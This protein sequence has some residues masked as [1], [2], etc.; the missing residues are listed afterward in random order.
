VGLI[1]WEVLL[2]LALSFS[3]PCR[4]AISASHGLSTCSLVQTTMWDP[5]TRAPN[6]WTTCPLILT[7][8]ARSSVPHL[9]RA[10]SCGHR[11]DAGEWDHLVG[12]MSYP[13]ELVLFV[14]RELA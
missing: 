13:N 6:R 4:S 1:S 14:T 3:P 12:S 8:G 2:Q 11:C 10:R 9:I 7:D 5:S